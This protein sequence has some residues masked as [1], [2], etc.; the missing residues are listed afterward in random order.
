MLKFGSGIEDLNPKLPA[1]ELAAIMEVSLKDASN[2]VY[3]GK[4]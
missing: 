4:M 1:E 3:S 2:R